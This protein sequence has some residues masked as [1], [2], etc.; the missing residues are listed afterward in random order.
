MAEPHDAP[1]R[2]SEV[3]ACVR[4]GDFKRA[5]DLMHDFALEFFGP[6]R[7]DEVCVMSGSFHALAV[8]E[9]KGEMGIDDLMTR[10]NRLAA[11]LLALLRELSEALER[12]VAHG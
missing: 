7:A 6:E 12:E 9:R 5:F 10:R 2:A 8:Y 4:G 11:N 3:R 1:R